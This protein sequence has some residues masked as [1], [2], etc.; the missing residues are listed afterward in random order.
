[1]RCQ[2][3]GALTPTRTSADYSAYAAG[4]A[5]DPLSHFHVN[6]ILFEHHLFLHASAYFFPSVLHALPQAANMFSLQGIVILFFSYFIIPRLTFLPSSVHTLL[7]VFGPFLLPKLLD[8]FNT[9]RAVSRSVSVRPTP[10]KIQLALNLLFAST[11]VCLILSLPYFAPENIFIKTQSRLQIAPDV[12]FNRLRLLRP[13]TEKDEALQTKFNAYGGNKL[14]Y[15]AHGPD[16]L[17][18]CIWCASSDGDDTSNYML[19][20]LPKIATPHILHLAVLGLATSS[21]VGKEGSRFRTKGM[22][23]GLALAVLEIWYLSFYDISENK[24]AKILDD[25]DFLHWRLRVMRFTSFAIMDAVLAAVL[26][27][28]STNRWLAKPPSIA[29]RIETTTRQ[30]EE[31]LNKSRALG[32]LMNSVNRDPALRGV[33]EEY[34]RTEGQVMAAMVQEE[35]VMATINRAVGVLDLRSLE[36]RVGE[37]ADGIL[38]GIDGMRASQVL[39]GSNIVDA[40]Q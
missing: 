5:G 18:N 7:I 31:N 11:V 1:M 39:S 30:A 36:G 6:H 12:L 29:E 22:I 19:Y 25:I 15:L 2:A 20:S 9:S 38:A 16:T 4:A 14:I 27:A 33:R 26:W 8:L 3:R 21:I 34:W 35:E 10:P 37:V 13:L 17:L 32:L 40:P 24:R 23:A 28:T